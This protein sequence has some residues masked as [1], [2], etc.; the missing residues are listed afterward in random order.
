[1]WSRHIIRRHLV[2]WVNA[3]TKGEHIAQLLETPCCTGTLT[4]VPRTPKYKISSH[5]RHIN[6]CEITGPRW[7]RRLRKISIAEQ[8]PTKSSSKHWMDIISIDE[9]HRL[10]IVLTMLSR[11][12][13]GGRLSLRNLLS[14]AEEGQAKAMST[15]AAS[16]E[17]SLMVGPIVKIM[18]SMKRLFISSVS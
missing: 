12:K 13:Y 3:T 4:G 2:M 11:G 1:M 10:F 14:G 17:A 15:M 8:T 9:P 5:H 6:R 16:S 7:T 18:R